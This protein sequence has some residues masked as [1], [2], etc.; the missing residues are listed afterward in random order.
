[1]NTNIV[2]NPMFA[3]ALTDDVGAAPEPAR[4]A[5]SANGGSR[6]ILNPLT[7]EHL[8]AMAMRYWPDFLFA[9][10]IDRRLSNARNRARE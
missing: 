2:T 4:S 3:T 8:E 7:V 9:A 1:M 10:A 5:R 6:R